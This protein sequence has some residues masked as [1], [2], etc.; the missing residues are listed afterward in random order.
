M[1][2]TS[3]HIIVLVARVLGGAVPGYPGTNWYGY[4]DL[5]YQLIES[6]ST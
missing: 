4:P 2:K 1:V 5:M 6:I 3:D